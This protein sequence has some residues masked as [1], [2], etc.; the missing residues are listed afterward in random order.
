[1]L[2]TL[3]YTAFPRQKFHLA[4]SYTVR[5]PRCSHWTD[6]NEPVNIFLGSL[7]CSSTDASHVFVIRCLL[8]HS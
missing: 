3:V 4:K 6:I 8:Q 1:M 5:L 2:S 7:L